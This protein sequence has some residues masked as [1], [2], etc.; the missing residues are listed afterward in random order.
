MRGLLLYLLLILGAYV[1]HAVLY[2]VMLP[3]ALRVDLFLIL[4]LHASFSY[5]RYRTLLLA[6]FL[7][8]LMDV[9][10]PVRGCYHPLI[11]LVIAFLAST[12]WQNLNLHTR[13]YRALFLGLCTLLEG[14]DIWIIMWLQGA[15]FVQIP[16]ALEILV[17]RTITTALVGPFLLA[18]LERVDLWL[19]TLIDVQ[20]SQE[21]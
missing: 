2:P 6:L 14:S 16:Y 5:E 9:G 8:V 20:E 12:L 19:S 7:G 17:G 4:L 13:R 15:E 21:A 1:C 10:L 18:G 3:S 11:Y